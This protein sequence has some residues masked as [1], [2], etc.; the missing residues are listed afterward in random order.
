MIRILEFIFYYFPTKILVY[1][2]LPYISK[3]LTK[4]NP[5]YIWDSESLGTMVRQGLGGYRDWILWALAP[6]DY[7]FF[8]Y[9]IMLPVILIPLTYYLLMGKLGIKSRMIK[10]LVAFS[11]IASPIVFGDFSTGQTFWVYLTL[12]WLFFYAYQTFVT[13]D[14]VI[15]NC[16]ILSV[17]LFLTFGFLP[18][19]IVPLAFILTGFIFTLV[20]SSLFNSRKKEWGAFLKKGIIVGL[21]FVSMALP[22]LIVA[23]SGQKA[24]ASPSA[25]EDYYHNYSKTIFLNTIRLAGNAG[26]GQ[27]TLGYNNPANWFN[28][29]GYIIFIVILFA[30][31]APKKNNDELGKWTAPLLITVLGIFSFMHLL[32][33]SPEVGTLLFQSQWIV[34]SI[35]SPTKIF[36]ILLP[37]LAILFGLSLDHLV[38]PFSPRTKTKV[39]ST[40]ALLL[41]IYGWPFFRGDFG[42]LHNRS[43]PEYFFKNDLIQRISD[44]ANDSAARSLVIPMDHKDELN[45]ERIAPGLNTV[46]LG[47]DLPLSRDLINNII[48]AYNNK[49][50]SLFNYLDMAGIGN[51]F[52][53]KDN[54]YRDL[55]VIFPNNLPYND[56]VDFFK[57]NGFTASYEDSDFIQLTKLVGPQVYSSGSIVNLLGSSDIKTVGALSQP[58][59]LVIEDSNNKYSNYFDT[60]TVNNNTSGRITG[61]AVLYEPSI[62]KLQIEKNGQ[63]VLIYKKDLVT[64]EK[65]KIFEKNIQSEANLLILNNEA[66]N[67]TSAAQTNVRSGTQVLKETFL[68]PVADAG[69]DYSFEED[70]PTEVND[71]S[72][73]RF[74]KAEIYANKSDQATNGAKSLLIG[75]SSHLAYVSRSLPVGLDPHKIYKLSFDYKNIKGIPPSFT[76]WQSGANVG[77]P[78]GILSANKNWTTFETFFSPEPGATKLDLYL[79][80][81]GGAGKISENL[82]DNIRL[83][84]V[85]AVSEDNFFIPAYHSVYDIKDQEVNYA[86]SVG[87]NL[88]NNPSFENS[89]FWDEAGDASAGAQGDP[90]IFVKKSRD[91]AVG[92]N[93]LSLTSFN[94][95]AYIRQRIQNFELNAVYK[96]SFYYK[97]VE[98]NQPSFAIRQA[99]INKSVPSGKLPPSPVWQ[100]Y[101]TYFVPAESAEGLDLFFYSSSGGEIST[102]LFDQVE[103]V[104]T[105]LIKSFAVLRQKSISKP[106][107]LL[108]DYVSINPTQIN[109][110]V[111]NLT[112]PGLMVYNESYHQ[113]WEAFVRDPKGKNLLLEN[114]V[115]ANGFANG[116]WLDP[117]EIP[118]E[119]QNPDGTYNVTLQ[120]KPQK[121][122]SLGLIISATV[123]VWCLGFLINN[124]FRK[125]IY[126]EI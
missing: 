70:K 104:K 42:L 67:L 55:F 100:Y 19:I 75:S 6:N 31:L 120:F 92:K 38:R 53:K 33:T 121:S 97:N 103:I 111:K 22:Y 46:R 125:K 35:R 49:D 74:G 90:Q 18:P 15:K 102:N 79:Y 99:G 11:A 65:T 94:H 32:A 80:T 28:I 72:T 9:K 66:I 10:L 40:I 98:G 78:S 24:Y 23:Q 91:A 118:V 69:L 34:T 4:F 29:A 81:D 112:S 56:A 54:T 108:L 115:I 85:N 63:N 95:T 60:Y 45:F 93:S 114:H 84:E 1:G 106:S 47:G 126:A 57:T 41:A 119:Y 37:M 88:I 68:S 39:F 59:N 109:I 101:E 96:L 8:F 116:W 107:E 86:T 117:T 5:F 113:G 51:I 82:F 58:N 21:L 62:V 14:V 89:G 36:V 16:V 50:D 17:L 52:L 124:R 73:G 105:P 83:F 7:F 44:R 71:A 27:E 77:L 64:G 26:N 87:E 123:F 25:L 13:Q 30:F 110:Q 76:I 61:K 48:A 20:F 3:A 43:N 2:D 12:P 122:F